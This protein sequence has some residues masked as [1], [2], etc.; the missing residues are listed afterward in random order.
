MILVAVVAAT[1]YSA[2]RGGTLAEVT[3][4]A[5]AAICDNV[6]QH[7]GYFKLT[8]GRKHYFYWFFESRSAPKT[9]PLVLW[10]TGGP[11]CSSEVALFG[12]NGPCSV[13]AAGT[14]TIR[15]KY[16]WN[17]RAN[18][19]YIDQPAGT[20]F[21]YGSGLDHDEAGVARDMY[22]FLQQLLQAHPALQPLDFYVVGESYAGHY[23]PAVTHE[24]WANNK[25]LPSGAIQINL[26]G[27]VDPR[28]AD[29]RSDSTS[30][31]TRDERHISSRARPWPAGYRRDGL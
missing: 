26:K 25:A 3:Q 24:V 13:N 4:P 19:V 1:A 10:M 17:T 7:S 28:L 23:V 31:V 21:S 29:I 6:T 30:R 9:D 5:S 18:L 8:T 22:D 2:A 27:R 20:G 16:S 14:G 11:G 15:N 12:E